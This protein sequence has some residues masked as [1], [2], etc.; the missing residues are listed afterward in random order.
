MRMMLIAAL[1]AFVTHSATAVE[2][3]NMRSN[4]GVGLGTLLFEAIGS[5]GL[6]SQ[7]A[8]ATTNGLF[9]NQLFFVSSGTGGAKSWD[10]IV[11]NRPAAEFLRDNLDAIARDMASG[12]GEALTTFAELTGVAA[13]DRAAF[14][15]RLQNNYAR[16]FTSADVTSEVVLANIGK[17]MA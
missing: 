3:A 2:S 17:V 12:Q 8:A 6:L 13:A 10:G 5:E 11:H 14:F 15:A 16:I 1:A 4:V 7:T 9:L